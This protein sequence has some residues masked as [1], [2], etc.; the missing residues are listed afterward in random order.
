MHSKRLGKAGM[1]VG[2][3][4]KIRWPRTA[5]PIVW[6]LVGDLKDVTQRVVDVLLESPPGLG[7]GVPTP[8]GL[9]ARRPV[10]LSGWGDGAAREVRDVQGQRGSCTGR[11]KSLCGLGSPR[12]LSE[13]GSQWRVL[14]RSTR[15]DLGFENKTGV[16]VVG[17]GEAKVEAE[18]PF[19]RQTWTPARDAGSWAGE[20]RV[21]GGVSV[22]IQGT[23]GKLH[24][25]ERNTSTPLQKPRESPLTRSSSMPASCA[26][27]APALPVPP[28]C[29]SP[30]EPPGLS[31]AS[32]CLCMPRFFF[33]HLDHFPN[34][35]F[36]SQFKYHS[37]FET[38][39]YSPHLLGCFFLHAI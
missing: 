27:T 25:W 38:S 12:P 26:P 3:S 11:G 2:L 4:L 19:R 39:P 30:P 13:A 33:L 18:R 10:R 16:L 34:S 23:V 31:P 35:T 14:R 37:L 32:S 6:S 24:V 28:W 7:D 17:N 9:K 21:R 29:V 20:K 1:G 22:P 5:S 8:R 36:K 15:C